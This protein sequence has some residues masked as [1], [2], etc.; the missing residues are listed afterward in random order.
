[1][2]IC[3]LPCCQGASPRL[4]GEVIPPGANRQFDLEEGLILLVSL[5]EGLRCTTE[6]SEAQ[7]PVRG[8]EHHLSDR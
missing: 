8:G 4:Q 1:M 3:H 2:V 5:G 6:P 7:E